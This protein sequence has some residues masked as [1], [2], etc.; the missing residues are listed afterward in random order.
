MTQLELLNSITAVEARLKALTYGDSRKRG[1]TAD[2]FAWLNEMSAVI[3]SL[4]DMWR[5]VNRGI[6][7]PTTEGLSR[8]SIAMLAMPT[9]ARIRDER[10]T[11]AT[12]MAMKVSK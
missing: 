4:G 7:A 9:V 10:K 1:P 2:Y 11:R 5:A 3:L 8:P 12:S 6:D